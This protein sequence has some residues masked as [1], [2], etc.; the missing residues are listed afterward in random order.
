MRGIMRGLERALISTLEAVVF[1]LPHRHVKSFARHI[2]QATTAGLG[3][4]IGTRGPREI[5][6]GLKFSF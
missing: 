1:G 3:R 2:L 6:F 5:Q 4:V